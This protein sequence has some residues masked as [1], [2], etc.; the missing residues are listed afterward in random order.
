M[1]KLALGILILIFIAGSTLAALYVQ[2]VWELP[3]FIPASP[4]VEVPVSSEPETETVSSQEEAEPPEPVKT[5]PEFAFDK[6]AEDVALDALAKEYDAVGISVVAFQDAK[7]VYT[8]NYGYQNLAKKI[9]CDENTKYRVASLSKTFS[10]ITACKLADEGII[11]LDEDVGKYLGYKVRSPRFPNVPITTRMLL[12]HTS[13]IFDG[14]MYQQSVTTGYVANQTILSGGTCYSGAEPGTQYRYSNFGMALIGAIL[15]KATN[16]YFSDS[17]SEK[18]MKPLGMDASYLPSEITAKD[19]IADL[20][21]AGHGLTRSAAKQLSLRHAFQ[22]GYSQGMSQGSLVISAKDYAAGLM[23]V[24]NGGELNGVRILKPETAKDITTIQFT[25]EG[26]R[27]A[28][29]MRE[30]KEFAE[31]PLLCHS[32]DSY[33]MLASFA[34][35]PENNA[36]VV[37]ITNGCKQLYDE[38]TTYFR[39]CAEIMR[40]LYTHYK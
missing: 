11:D 23:M 35:D 22:L 9:P 34:V 16:V 7:I 17:A 36:G 6:S 40:E 39:V 26:A 30:W 3:A 25:S 28:L 15:E 12:T 33:G 38:K 4:P 13:S 20:Y 8:Y 24:L 19:K 27:E 14:A 2:G 5:G 18:F 31:R 37:V 10:A 1:K 32:G 21:G 29:C